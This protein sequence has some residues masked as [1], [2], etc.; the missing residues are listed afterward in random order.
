VN[1]LVWRKTPDGYRSAGYRIRR[2]EVGSPTPWRLEASTS[3]APWSGSQP[4]LSTHPTLRDA[5]ERAS[6]DE[7]QRIRRARVTGHCTIGI[8][9]ALGFVAVSS[10]A[11]ALSAAGF[12]SAM[13]LFYLALESFA[14][15]LGVSLGHPP[16]A[17]HGRREPD[18]LTWS[19]RWVLAMVEGPRRRNWAVA[20]A[21][22]AP[23]VRALPPPPAR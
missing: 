1:D 11:L 14:D 3:L 2:L 4:T 18:R 15:A 19:A 23:A 13:G 21:D 20:P 7:R 8:A 6:R 22:P 10:T 16:A 12:F 17:S 5:R 9:A